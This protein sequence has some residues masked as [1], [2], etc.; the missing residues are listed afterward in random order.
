MKPTTIDI[1]NSAPLTNGGEIQFLSSLV[2]ELEKRGVSAVFLANF[3]TKKDSR[4]IDCLVALEGHASSVEVKHFTG[5]VFG[6]QNNPWQ[7]ETPSGRRIAYEGENPYRQTLGAKFAI[8]DDMHRF[9][10]SQSTV[11]RPLGD[12]FYHEFDA[13]VCCV[14]GLVDG[15]KVTAGDKKVY[16]RS[17]AA[18]V[19]DLFGQRLQSAWKLDDWRRFAQEF[20]GLQKVTVREAI[21]Q[22]FRETKQHVATY[23]TRFG[24]FYGMGLATLVEPPQE[25]GTKLAGGE[26]LVEEIVRSGHHHLLL[27]PSGMGKTLHLKYGALSAARNG[28]LP[29]WISAAHYKGD[30]KTLLNGSIAHC[31]TGSIATLLEAAKTANAQLFL[32]VDAFNGCDERR[33]P[34]LLQHLQAF[35]LRENSQVVIS[36]THPI[37][38]P[39]EL[40]C[41]VIEFGSLTKEWKR[42]L[43]AH[44]STAAGIVD[45]DALCAPFTTVMDIKIA[46]ECAEK[47]RAPVTRA[48]LYSSYVRSVAV[49]PSPAVERRVFRVL[50][51]AMGNGCC[52]A[53]PLADF[54]RIA[55]TTIEEV[56]AKLEV[57]DRLRSSRL[58][59][60]RW[61]H[62]AFSHE[63]FLNFFRAESLS[64]QDAD[65]VELAR[66]LAQPGI[67]GW[68][69]LCSR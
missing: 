37:A 23:L 26:S 30:F 7:I 3:H 17:Y 9:A 13:N 48:A 53:L 54:E 40:E 25:S 69:N 16:V 61:D 56:G 44:Y 60:F 43:F 8:S 52:T 38:L 50:A 42:R 41:K 27:G 19:E 4:Q 47:L 68:K 57:V 34:E 33:K 46:A 22:A 20:Y 15:S 14:P 67:V 64:R 10:G 66:L 11:P 65:C 59:D 55:E 36:S 49:S 6:D 31:F 51:E 21:D 5:R 2:E 1:Y 32:V 28:W 35:T 24:E 58:L 45:V 18:F 39:A 62:V 63:L 29:I 12:K